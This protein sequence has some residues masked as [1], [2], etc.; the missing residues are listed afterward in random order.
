MILF[1]R[2]QVSVTEVCTNLQI[3]SGLRLT[4]FFLGYLIK[5]Y[6]RNAPFFAVFLYVATF[7]KAPANLLY[8][9]KNTIQ[10]KSFVVVSFI[11]FTH[12]ST[13]AF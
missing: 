2:C 4:F 13:K 8:I 9:W 7:M 3:L 5:S 6:G 10:K 11:C 12:R 1:Q